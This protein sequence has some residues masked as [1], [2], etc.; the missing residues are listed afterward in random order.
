MTIQCSSKNNAENHMKKFLH[1]PK[2]CLSFKPEEIACRCFKVMQ[3]SFFNNADLVIVAF[4]EFYNEIF[5]ASRPAF[6][7][8]KALWIVIENAAS[9]HN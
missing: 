8:I 6:S 2:L 1:V 5:I 7:K 3:C 4:I 9:M